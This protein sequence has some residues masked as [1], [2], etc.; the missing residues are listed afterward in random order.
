MLG[1]EGT[2]DMV[3]R[4]IMAQESE[5]T[6][7]VTTQD[8]R[9]KIM[10]WLMQEQWQIGQLST[11]D[12]VWV[13]SAQDMAG[14]KI[15]VGQKAQSID[16]IIIQAGIQISEPDRQRIA[17]LPP[18]ERTSFLWDLRFSLLQTGTEFSGIDDNPQLIQLNQRIYFD[19]LTKD[20]F[21][22]RVCHVR[23]AVTLVQWMFARKL[24]QPPPPQ[25][26]IGF[27]A[28]GQT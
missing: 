16:Q 9:T 11:P 23:D 19:G 1:Y 28:P 26:H 4:D 3:W 24:L 6:L 21:L 2:T 20:E 17:S 10:A 12:A 5:R 14:R 25:E 7:S 15:V 18:Q 13:L 27:K 22:H 8:M